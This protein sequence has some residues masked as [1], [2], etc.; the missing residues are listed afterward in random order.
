LQQFQ[1]EMA[2]RNLNVLVEASI[3]KEK[4]ITKESID[5]VKNHV[6]TKQKAYC[7]AKGNSSFYKKE[8]QVDEVIG[9]K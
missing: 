6:T 8:C 3:E 4:P 2:Q 1:D 5:P 9:E 7:C